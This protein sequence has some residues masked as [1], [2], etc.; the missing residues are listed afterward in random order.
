MPL[1]EKMTTREESEEHLRDELR[2]R[3]EKVLAEGFSNVRRRFEELR[4]AGI[5]DEKGNLLKRVERSSRKDS[6]YGGWG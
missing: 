1:P 4:K 5:V 2:D 6:D 3:D